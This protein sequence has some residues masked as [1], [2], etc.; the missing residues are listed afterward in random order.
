MPSS[1]V[2]VSG[3]PAFGEWEGHPP[4]LPLWRSAPSAAFGLPRGSEWS[5]DAA[6]LLPLLPLLRA[7]EVRGATRRW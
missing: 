4:A 6:V 1:A 2:S 3:F 7:R 5:G